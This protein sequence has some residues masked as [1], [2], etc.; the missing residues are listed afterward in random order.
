TARVRLAR[1]C[2]ITYWSRTAL[3]SLG[4]G[5]RVMLSVTSRSSSSARISLQRV[6]HSLQMYTD[7]PEMNF[8]TESLLLPQ[9]LQRRCLSVDIG[10]PG[11][12]GLLWER[13]RA[14]PGGSRRAGGRSGGRAVSA[15]GVTVHP[16]RL[17][18]CPPARHLAVLL[19]GLDHL[20]DQPVLLRLLGAHEA[21][22][23]HVPLDPLERL[24]GVLRVE[25]VHLAAEVE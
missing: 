22:P 6:M 19:L 13:C 9:K 15:A 23:V 24:A 25:L 16:V 14:G 21:V 11:C 18:A 2:P 4:E 20:V 3:I 5:T 10:A 17:A 1:S 12:R 8:R 7:G